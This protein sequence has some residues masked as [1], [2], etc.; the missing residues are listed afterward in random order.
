MAE[1]WASISIRR[2]CSAS[3]SRRVSQ[4]A[5]R[6]PVSQSASSTPAIM[7]LPPVGNCIITRALVSAT[8]AV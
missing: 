7:V 1:M 8:R 4:T 3:S 5:L 2:V 6:P